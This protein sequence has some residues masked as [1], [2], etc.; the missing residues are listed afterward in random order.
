MRALTPRFGRTSA[1][2]RKTA[3]VAPGRT[4]ACHLRMVAGMALVAVLAGCGWWTERRLA[5]RWETVDTP[6]RTLDLRGDHT[7]TQ[8]LSG[9]TLGFVSDLL[10]PEA[11]TWGVEGEALVLTRTDE[12]GVQQIVRLPIHELG[13]DSAVLGSERWMRKARD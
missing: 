5:G 4:A 9:K 1:S 7:Y 11:G 6:K 13:G 8:R 2:L 10:G 12:R 3:A